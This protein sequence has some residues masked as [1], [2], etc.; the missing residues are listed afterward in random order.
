MGLGVIGK[1]CD[2]KSLHWRFKDKKGCDDCGHSPMQHTCFWH[3]EILTPIQKHSFSGPGKLAFKKLHIL[4][5]RIMLRRTKLQKAEDL[6]LPPRTIVVRRDF[7]S[8]E[9]KE[10]YLSLFSDAKRE[11]ST[12]VDAGTLLNSTPFP[13]PS[14]RLRTMLMT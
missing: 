3:N 5:D 4:L 2:C 12:Y 6:G 13:L 11:F 10:L 9:E 7:F 8:P 1:R 14:S